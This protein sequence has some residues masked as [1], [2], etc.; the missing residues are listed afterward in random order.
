MTSYNPLNNRTT[1]NEVMN[2]QELKQEQ[3]RQLEIARRNERLF[4]CAAKA[5]QD[6]PDGVTINKGGLFVILTS[7]DLDTVQKK[8][9]AGDVTLD[10]ETGLY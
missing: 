1:V 2:E 7:V 4:R 9:K 5:I 6:N 10:K 3:Q 8:L